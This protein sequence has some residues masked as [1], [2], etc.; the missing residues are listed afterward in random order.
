MS[1]STRTE[2]FVAAATTQSSVAKY[3]KAFTTAYSENRF[4]V[5]LCGPSISQ[6]KPAPA[7]ELRIRLKNALLDEDF[8]VVL[9]EDDGLELLRRE[10][11]GLADDN[12]FAYVN[13]CAGAVVIVAHSPGSFCELGLF[14]HVCLPFRGGSDY[15]GDLVLVANAEFEKEESYFNNGPARAVD[16]LGGKVFY[17]DFSSF[18]VRKVVERLM[19]R[20]TVW[21]N[22]VSR[23]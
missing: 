11:K 13:R 5:F 21:L 19:T 15:K 1:E 9:G 16:T 12:E 6:D 10:Y 7:A 8:E 23:G 3:R 22:G 2:S 4:V 17:A 14:A 18:D 20:R